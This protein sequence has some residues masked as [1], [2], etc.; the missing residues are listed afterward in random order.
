MS[1]PAQLLVEELWS[2]ARKNFPE[3]VKLLV[4]HGA[5]VNTPGFRDGRTP[6]EAAL[7]AGNHEIA[8]YLLQHGAKKIGLDPKETFAAA[9]I[10]G[11]RAEARALLEADPGLLNELG[12]HGRV[13]LVHRA[14]EARRPEGVRLLAE[15]GFE[16]GGMTRNTP[17]HNAAWAGDLEMVELLVELGADPNLREPTY[18][19]TPLG[20]AAHNQQPHVVRYLLSFATAL[21]AVQNDGLERARALLE[22]DPSLANTTDDDGNPLVFYLHGG[23]KRLDEMIELLLTHGAALNLR[24][25]QGRTILDEALKRGDDDLAN[26]LRRH[27]AKTAPP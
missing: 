16:L 8:A 4:E 15:L 19:A 11:R 5:D 10:A 14:V 17:M 9:C 23:L 6:Y 26:V 20:W 27:G 24:N 21:D 3:R 25:K 22:E 2:A 18:H 1:S 13:E 12:L 7:L